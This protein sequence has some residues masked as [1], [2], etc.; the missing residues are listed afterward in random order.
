MLNIDQ[1]KIEIDISISFFNLFNTG[2]YIDLRGLPDITETLE[3]IELN[4][5]VEIK[6]YRNIANFL[7]QIYDIFSKNKQNFDK[8][9]E[10]QFSHFIY[11]REYV[12]ML[13]KTISIDGEI[14]DNATLSLFTIR[15][16]INRIKN[17]TSGTLSS[18]INKFGKY[19]SIDRPIIRNERQCLAVKS[20][21][22]SRVKG[23]FVGKSD[24]GSTFFIE[25]EKLIELNEELL[26]LKSDEKT[27]ISKIISHINF[28]TVKRLKSIKN[29]IKVISYID[30]MIGKANYAINNKGIYVTPSEQDKKIFFNGLRHPLIPK[31]EVIPLNLKLN[32]EGMII[33]GPNT[34]GKT[35]TLKS[36][37]LAFLLSHAGFPILSYE[38]KL[39]YIKNIFTDIGDSQSVTQNLSTFSSH[40]KNLK[41]ILDEANEY[42]LILIDELG[43][44]TDPIEG[45]ALGRAIIK[46]LLN[47]NSILFITSHL[48]EIKT[49]SIEEKRLETASMSFDVQTLRPTY[50]ILIGVPGASH[51][52]EI[53]RRMGFDEEL[54]RDAQ[55][56]IGEE[57]IKS[58]HLFS[59]MANSFETIEEEKNKIKMK[60]YEIEQLKKQYEKKYQKLKNK[61]VEKLDNETL[62][63][64]NEIRFLKNEVYNIMSDIKHASNQKNT[65]SLKKNLKKLEDISN[66]IEILNKK[67]E[68]K[69]SYT[70]KVGMDVK[71]PGGTIGRVISIKKNKAEIKIENSPINLTYNINELIPTK[72]KEKIN[73]VTSF[74]N[75]S[76]KIPEIDLRGFTVAESIPEIENLISDMLF[77]NFNKGYIIHGKGTGKLSLGIWEYLRN[78][79]EIKS[80]RVGKPNEGGTGVTVV[81]V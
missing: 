18:L 20:E 67:N 23:M 3:K 57:Y 28:E 61:E 1:I 72:K 77:S 2:K 42:S 36:I 65:D 26:K 62:K 79:K 58:E 73:K 19:L 60:K 48:S 30:S 76:T 45:A 55:N 44:G 17:K 9:I 35:V 74:S 53:S 66:K 43:T 34:G 16:N 12:S 32:E 40:L 69:N 29:N 50:K 11:H 24:S 21:Y 25:P 6:E 39:P 37:G 59:K 5:L 13:Y 52:I 31:S 10:E 15:K 22:R 54:L 81:E 47:K 56:N 63:L 51:A 68:V 71:A 78:C 4:S 70:I 64:K 38:A 7:N 8:N 46:R 27:E 41:I 75:S 80:F 14:E 33:T 49:Y